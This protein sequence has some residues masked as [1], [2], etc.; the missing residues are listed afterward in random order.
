MMGAAIQYLIPY[1]ID[2]IK[3]KMGLAAKGRKQLDDG[4]AFQLRERSMPYGDDF[5]AE[6]SDIGSQNAYSWD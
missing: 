4:D 6:N 1:F 3:K 5:G 2:T